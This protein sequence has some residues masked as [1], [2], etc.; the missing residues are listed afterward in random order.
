MTSQIP[1]SYDESEHVIYGALLSGLPNSTE[2]IKDPSE[3]SA[4]LDIIDFFFNLDVTHC[5]ATLFILTKRLPAETYIYD[6]VS[7]LKKYHAHVTL[8]VSNNSFGG[9]SSEQMYR[10]ASETNG[11][12]IFT[13]DDW[14]QESPFWLPSIWPS[15]LVYSVNAVV[16]KSGTVA[17]PI[18]NSPLVGYYYIC[19]TL[20]DHGFLDTFRMVHLTWSDAGSLIISGSF[21]ETVESHI[22]FGNTTYTQKGPYTL[23]AIPYDMTLQYEFLGETTEVLQIRIYS[24][25]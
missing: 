23:D 7:K 11:L 22:D 10:L 9:S 12:C 8:V 16:I 18:F 6:L 4:V 25:K 5:G 19:M 21:E 20:Q 2:S 17:L 15:Y 3:G 24:E 14:I 13:E 1:E